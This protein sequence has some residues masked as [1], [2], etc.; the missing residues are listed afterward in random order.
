MAKKRVTKK[1]SKKSTPKRK[2][3]KPVRKVSPVKSKSKSSNIMVS[4]RKIR[5]TTNS[6]IYSGIVFVLSLILFLI[7]SD[8]L[9]SLFGFIMI[10]SGALVILFAVLE[11]IYYFMKRK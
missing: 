6:L 7:T 10:I 5:K 1:V 8:F 3:K 11:I 9:E 4:E 2:L